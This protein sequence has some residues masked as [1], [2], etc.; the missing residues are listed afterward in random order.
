MAG[1]VAYTTGA[2]VSKSA[3]LT[4]AHCLE[5]G[6]IYKVHIGR[7]NRVQ[8]VVFLHSEIC[9]YIGIYCYISEEHCQ[10]RG[11]QIYATPGLPVVCRVID[12]WNT[13]FYSLLPPLDLCDTPK[14][15]NSLKSGKLVR[16]AAVTGLHETAPVWLCIHRWAEWGWVRLSEAEWGLVKDLN[17]LRL[18]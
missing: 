15:K 7:F 5:S 2:L 9:S 11:K 6:D 16:S 4:A 12:S 8:W 3:V 14:L 13:L 1:C 18:F 10:T 17:L